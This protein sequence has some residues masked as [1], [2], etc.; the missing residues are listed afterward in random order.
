[1]DHADV[2]LR[3]R[4]IVVSTRAAVRSFADGDP[5]VVRVIERG[6]VLLDALEAS[7]H[8]LSGHASFEQARAEL[9]ALAPEA[10]SLDGAGA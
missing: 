1:M 5:Q 9:A 6:Q 8:G 7:E 10:V 4:V 3:V 2:L